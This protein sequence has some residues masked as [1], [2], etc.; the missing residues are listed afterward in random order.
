M[1]E[2]EK[3]CEYYDF[4]IREYKNMRY[5]IDTIIECIPKTDPIYKMEFFI[6]AIPATENVAKGIL[7]GVG[8]GFLALSLRYII[9]RL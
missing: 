5:A 8:A 2:K 4:K 7:G 1:Q 9:F 3:I 6:F